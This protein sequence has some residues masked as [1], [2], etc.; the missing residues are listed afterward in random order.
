[1]HKEPPILTTA[2]STLRGVV[3]V[4]YGRRFAVDMNYSGHAPSEHEGQDSAPRP[5]AVVVMA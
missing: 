4:K 1:M 5:D 2:K 3:P